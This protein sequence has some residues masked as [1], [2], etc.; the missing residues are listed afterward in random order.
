MGMG[1]KVLEVAGWIGVAAG[2][3][4]AIVYLWLALH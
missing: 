2:I 3:V 4:G 1:A